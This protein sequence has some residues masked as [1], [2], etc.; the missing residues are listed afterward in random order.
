M[1]SRRYI[2]ANQ[3]VDSAQRVDRSDLNARDEDSVLRVLRFNIY[4]RTLKND[5]R[6]DYRRSRKCLKIIRLFG[7]IVKLLSK[8]LDAIDGNMK[9]Y[10]SKREMSRLF[11]SR[12]QEN[13]RKDTA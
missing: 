2:Q 3:H 8:N 11:R 9:Y 6:G 10:P 13:D 12:S 7:I 4:E 5:G 1:H